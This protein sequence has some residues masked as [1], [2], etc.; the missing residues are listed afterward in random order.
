LAAA[1]DTSPACAFMKA[2]T[3]G[4]TFCNAASSA[5]TP[6]AVTSAMTEAGTFDSAVS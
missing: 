6:G 5:E 1:D 4:G 2:S 3:D